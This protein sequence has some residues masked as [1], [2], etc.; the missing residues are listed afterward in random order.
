M[1]K[2]QGEARD[3]GCLL[4]ALYV[5]IDGQKWLPRLEKL[6][7]MQRSKEGLWPKAVRGWVGWSDDEIRLTETFKG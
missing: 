4:P 7:I 6:A 1:K 3:G 5:A 2:N